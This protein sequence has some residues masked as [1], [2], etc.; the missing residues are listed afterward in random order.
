M[1]GPLWTPEKIRAAQTTPRSVAA[2]MSSYAGKSFADFNDLHRFS[3]HTEFFGTLL[4]KGG[5][6]TVLVSYDEDKV[7]RRLLRAGATRGS[8][9]VA[10]GRRGRGRTGERHLPTCWK[11]SSGNWRL[12]VRQ[13][14]PSRRASA[15]L[16]RCARIEPKVLIAS[17]PKRPARASQIGRL[18]GSGTATI[19]RVTLTWT[20]IDFNL[21]ASL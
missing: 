1:S 11:R 14:A 20:P 21:Y 10:R 2:W 3:R 6:D 8:C 12:S 19:A 9:R 4:H 7:K 17:V 5:A 13:L 16:D 18:P 15:M